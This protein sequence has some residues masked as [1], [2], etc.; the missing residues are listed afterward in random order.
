MAVYTTRAL[1]LIFAAVLLQLI[2]GERNEWT[3]KKLEAVLIPY[4]PTKGG[5]TGLRD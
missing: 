1:V 3:T 5:E 4:R 2:R